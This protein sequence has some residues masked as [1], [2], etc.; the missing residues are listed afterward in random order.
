MFYTSAEAYLLGGLRDL[1]LIGST[2][3]WHGNDLD[4]TPDNTTI[5]SSKLLKLVENNSTNSISGGK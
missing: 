2:K 3:S 4:S 5:Q 1:I